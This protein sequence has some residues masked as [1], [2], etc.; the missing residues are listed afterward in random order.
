MSDG[1][2][3]L[4]NIV[5]HAE[6]CW[7]QVRSGHEEYREAIA[8]YEDELKE[9]DCRYSSP[10]SAGVR[11]SSART[12]PSVTGPTAAPTTCSITH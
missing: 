11:K 6:L 2:F 12:S 1:W 5:E 3:W 10:T 4:A 9:A 7:T 8:R